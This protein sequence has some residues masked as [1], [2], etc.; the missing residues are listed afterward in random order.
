MA[1]IHTNEIHT[2]SKGPLPG[3]MKYVDQTKK[4]VPRL[5][6][7]DP[8]VLV[9]NSIPGGQSKNTLVENHPEK[10]N[11]APTATKA[12]P[13]GK[14][15]PKNSKTGMLTLPYPVYSIDYNIV[16]DHKKSRANITYFDLMK[17]M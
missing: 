16:D 7:P 6:A 14:L 12:T 11:T 2:R 15:S 10:E 9:E 17:L 5:K 13:N 1:E 8:K 3:A 4:D